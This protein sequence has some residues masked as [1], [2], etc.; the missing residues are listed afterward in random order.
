MDES[1]ADRAAFAARRRDGLDNC[2][3]E[4]HVSLADKGKT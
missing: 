1:L 2:M 3:V 4:G